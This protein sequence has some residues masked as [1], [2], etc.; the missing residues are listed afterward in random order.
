[1]T[2]CLPPVVRNLCAAL[3]LIMPVRIE[4]N[5]PRRRFGLS[6]PPVMF[7]TTYQTCSKTNESVA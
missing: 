7:L 6:T 4:A 5:S 2:K 1:M 3:T